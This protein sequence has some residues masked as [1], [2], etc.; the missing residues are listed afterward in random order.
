MLQPEYGCSEIIYTVGAFPVDLYFND[1]PYD[2]YSNNE[3]HINDNAGDHILYIN[4][5]E[6]TNITKVL[7]D[8]KR[9]NSIYNILGQRLN[10]ISTNGIYIQGGEKYYRY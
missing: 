7:T 3:F 5:G 6:S 4:T 10:E 1:I 9:D 2:I 8:H